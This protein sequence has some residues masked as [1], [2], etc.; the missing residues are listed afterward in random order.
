MSL[1]CRRESK[2]GLRRT[3]KEAGEWGGKGPGEGG[4]KEGGEWVLRRF[5]GGEVRRQKDWDAKEAAEK[6]CRRMGR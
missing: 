1:L 2:R 3:S 5:E 6:K 4:G